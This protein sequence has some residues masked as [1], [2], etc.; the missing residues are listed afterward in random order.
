MYERR[1]N[2]VDWLEF[3]AGTKTPDEEEIYGK[4]RI[5]CS[6][7]Y[8]EWFNVVAVNT[9]YITSAKIIWEDSDRIDIITYRWNRY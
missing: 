4:D 6:S 8:D 3:Y 1:I 2:T 7:D 9:K 5:W